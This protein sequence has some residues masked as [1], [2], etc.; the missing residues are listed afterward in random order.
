MA[1]HD[2]ITLEIG[3]K[4]IN[5]DGREALITAIDTSDCLVANDT[6]GALITMAMGDKSKAIPMQAITHAIRIGKYRISA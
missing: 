5:A 6:P 2:G 3:T 1:K 4:I